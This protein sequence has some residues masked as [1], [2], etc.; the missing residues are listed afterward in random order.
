MFCRFV[1]RDS[2]EYHSYMTNNVQDQIPQI[3]EEEAGNSFTK[4]ILS[5]PLIL[6]SEDNRQRS[7][8][9]GKAKLTTI[10]QHYLVISVNSQRSFSNNWKRM[11]T[12]SSPIVTVC[13]VKIRIISNSRI[14]TP[15]PCHYFSKIW[16]NLSFK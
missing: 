12:T 10:I 11:R 4:S 14:S 8:V 2:I 6:C 16:R 1:S 3:E 9:L 7:F 5:R 13:G 15:P